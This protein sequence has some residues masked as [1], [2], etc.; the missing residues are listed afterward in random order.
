[1]TSA[2]LP[3]H[4]A[5]W[6]TPRS[7]RFS[8]EKPKFKVSKGTHHL[9][10]A[11]HLR[12]ANRNGLLTALLA[13]C[14]VSLAAA[15]VL[16]AFQAVHIGAPLISPSSAGLEPH[17]VLLATHNR[18]AWWVGQ[19]LGPQ[20]KGVEKEQT[21]LLDTKA[22]LSNCMARHSASISACSSIQHALQHWVKP[23]RLMVCSRHTAPPALC[24]LIEFTTN[25]RA[26]PA[27]NPSSRAA[28]QVTHWAH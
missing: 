1:M 5:R 12:L 14:V 3:L 9:L 6:S 25:V 13:L 2:V 24:A 4:R 22:S 10:V 27:I 16:V 15:T 7:D 18:L 28:E 17:R 23:S 8:A 19:T 11:L 21:L 20:A 26:G